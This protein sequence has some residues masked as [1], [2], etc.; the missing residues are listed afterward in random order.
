MSRPMNV[1]VETCWRNR[2]D[3][4]PRTFFVIERTTESSFTINIMPEAMRDDYQPKIDKRLAKSGV[5]RWAEGYLTPSRMI[6]H[7]DS[8]D[9]SDIKEILKNAFFGRRFD[10]RLKQFLGAEVF[11]DNVSLNFTI[12]SLFK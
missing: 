6:F 12:D 7:A 10:R 3:Y 4:S 8:L 1:L 5:V 9:K 2:G 11:I